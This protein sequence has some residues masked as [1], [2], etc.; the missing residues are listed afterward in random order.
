MEAA[1]RLHGRAHHDELGTAFHRD[2]RHVLREAAGPRADD[3][4][5]H[6]DAVR[7]GHRGGGLEPFPQAGEPTVHMRVQRQLALDDERRDENDAGPAVGG[8][9][10][11]EI[12]RVLGLLPVEERHDDAPVGDR[13]RP[14]REAARTPMEHLDVRHPH[15]RRW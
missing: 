6:R 8:E 9:A 7:T 12:E 3:L 10:A 11:G 4:P 1:A 2:A 15:R 5:P 14:A 13:A